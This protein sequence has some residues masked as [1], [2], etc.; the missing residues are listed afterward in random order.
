MAVAF[1]LARPE[2]TDAGKAPAAEQA[3]ATLQMNPARSTGG[4]DQCR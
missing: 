1:D 4:I 2:V 3:A